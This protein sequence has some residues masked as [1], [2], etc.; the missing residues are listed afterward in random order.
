MLQTDCSRDDFAAANFSKKSDLI[1]GLSSD[2][3]RYVQRLRNLIQR[4]SGY[5]ID[6]DTRIKQYSF[7]WHKSPR[8][9]CQVDYLR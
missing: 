5:H 1:G 3:K 2:R 6:G 4:I 8:R 7:A 9:F